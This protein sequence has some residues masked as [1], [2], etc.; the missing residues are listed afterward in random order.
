MLQ[1]II[2]VIGEDCYRKKQDKMSIDKYLFEYFNKNSMH[3]LLGNSR[4]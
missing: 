4:L 1:K 3:E 2:I